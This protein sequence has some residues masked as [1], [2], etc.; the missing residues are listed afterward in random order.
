MA[1]FDSSG[2]TGVECYYSEIA[3]HSSSFSPCDDEVREH[4]KA[5]RIIQNW[6]SFEVQKD[7]KRRFFF[8]DEN[9]GRRAITGRVSKAKAYEEALQF[10]N[11]SP[12]HPVEIGKPGKP[13]WSMASSSARCS[14]SSTSGARPITG[15]RSGT[16][17]AQRPACSG[18]WAPPSVRC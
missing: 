16:M 11:V 5:K 4:I 14:G 6:E 10:A 12:E 7:G 13:P 1:R 2:K 17:S 18:W 9:S 15:T 8:F 3:M